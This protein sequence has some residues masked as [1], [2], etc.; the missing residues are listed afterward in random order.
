M[1]WTPAE[2]PDHRGGPDP[3]ALIKERPPPRTSCRPPT[4]APSCWSPPRRRTCITFSPRTWHG[5]TDGYASPAGS[6]QRV[7][8]RT[9]VVLDVPV[10]GHPRWFSPRP[11]GGRPHP[12]GTV[13]RTDG[14]AWHAPGPAVC[15]YAS[16][17]V[18]STRSSL[19]ITLRC[20]SSV[21]CPRQDSNLRS[22]LRR[23]VLYPLSYGGSATTEE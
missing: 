10:E 17:K 19:P 15:R 4:P 13:T 9:R 3:T 2:P 6:P 1:T 16:W 12:R 5:P 8:R 14:R 21:T 7:R 20:C 23:A 11:R 18:A 22:R